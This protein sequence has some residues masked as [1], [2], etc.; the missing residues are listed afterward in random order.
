MAAAHRRTRNLI[1][2][3]D[4]NEYCLDG[5]V[6]EVV[7]LEPLA[8]KWT[9][10]GWQATTVD[11]HDVDALLGVF[12]ALAADTA[13]NRPAVVIA[14]TVKGKGVGFMEREPGWHLGYLDPADEER[15]LAELREGA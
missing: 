8:E 14:N 5:V 1:A 9:A 7:G 2:I 6:E 10:F 15:V 4:R 13:R 11:G 12:A 3:V